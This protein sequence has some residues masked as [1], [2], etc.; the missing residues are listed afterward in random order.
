[1][2]TLPS[3]GQFD[4]VSN[5]IVPYDGQST[6]T[7]TAAAA[8][9]PEPEPEPEPEI[10]IEC[11][12][13]DDPNGP[14]YI[15]SS[16][17][18]QDDPNDPEYSPS[19]DDPEY[20]PS[21][22]SPD[23]SPDAPPD[24]PPDD[25]GFE[26]TN[27]NS[28]CDNRFIRD[29]SSVCET[30]YY[31]SDDE[32]ETR[33]GFRGTNS[34]SGFPHGM[35]MR[36]GKIGVPKVNRLYTVVIDGIQSY[37]E[38]LGSDL[39]QW[40]YTVKDIQLR[41]MSP[42]LST[43]DEE[44]NPGPLSELHAKYG[45]VVTK[46]DEVCQLQRLLD[47]INKK[48]CVLFESDHRQS[49]QALWSPETTMCDL[50]IRSVSSSSVVTG[51]PPP[52]SS[53]SIVYITGTVLLPT[54]RV[55]LQSMSEIPTLGALKSTLL[56]NMRGRENVPKTLMGYKVAW[57]PSFGYTYEM[58]TC[59]LCLNTKP[60]SYTLKTTQSAEFDRMFPTPTRTIPDVSLYIGSLCAERLKLAIRA[61]KEK[62]N[63]A[64]FT[65]VCEDVKTF[66][67]KHG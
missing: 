42:S 46:Y 59:D 21:D 30:V 50:G 51:I 44:G 41:K 13:Q 52:E 36:D 37:F 11:D 15:P 12:P 4:G 63:L 34:T 38:Y 40:F 64:R 22:D 62:H 32:Q 5:S 45:I 14:E 29:D 18:P 9:K 7:P 35:F 66:V 24:A 19:S 43:D 20:N 17:D 3:D 55:E 56:S 57:N 67:T 48:S 39:I 8:A 31:S 10:E 49:L 33:S 2:I 60:L 47:A 16:D 23:D 28:D 61:E 65:N 27:D 53:R 1:M 26:G 58:G 6:S 25:H 54:Y